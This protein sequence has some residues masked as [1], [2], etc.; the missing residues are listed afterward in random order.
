MYYLIYYNIPN[1]LKVLK[2]NLYF[3]LLHR[4]FILIFNSL[5]QD[6]FLLYC[7]VLTKIVYNIFF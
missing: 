4:T 5:F 6:N 3:Y 7:D 2:Y 1:I